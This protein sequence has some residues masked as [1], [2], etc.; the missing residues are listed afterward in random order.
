MTKFDFGDDIDIIDISKQGENQTST[1]WHQGSAWKCCK[2]PMNYAYIPGTNIECQRLFTIDNKKLIKESKEMWKFNQV[3]V[4]E[5]LLAMF[6]VSY[7]DTK[8]H[9]QTDVC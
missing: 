1:L 2:G 6:D 8:I 4:L 9:I 5:R 3:W 7:F